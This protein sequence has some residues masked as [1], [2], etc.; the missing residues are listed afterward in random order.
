M[1]WVMR[2]SEETLGSRLVLLVLADHAK[3]DGTHAWPSVETIAEQA[4]LSERQTQRCLRSLVTSGAVS[5]TGKSRSG[6]SVYSVNMGDILSPM[7]VTFSTEGGD[8][9]V[10]RSVLKATVPEQVPVVS[11]Q[12][13]VG[14]Y[15]D[16]VGGV[17]PRRVIGMVA[18]Q[19][20]DL[21]KEGI[22]PPVIERALVL[23]NE[24]KLH[25]STLATLI[26][27]AANGKKHPRRYGIGLTSAEMGEMAQ[28]L[29]EAGR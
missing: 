29:R 12:A 1:S 2:H 21:L 18:K 19:V 20:G 6:T 7:G 17:V 28:R 16:Q 22:D 3:D 9:D 4:R 23:L 8:M 26:P 14:G 15:V 27:E 25:P 11:A 5:V 24:R 13:L 10:T